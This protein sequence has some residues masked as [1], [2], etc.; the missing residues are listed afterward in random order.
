[1]TDRA[2]QGSGGS[3]T[4]IATLAVKNEDIVQLL[5]RDLVVVDKNTGLASPNPDSTDLDEDLDTDE[6]LCVA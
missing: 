5:L 6:L 4:A 2:S 3:V 1:M